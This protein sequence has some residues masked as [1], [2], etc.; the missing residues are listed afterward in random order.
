MASINGEELTQKVKLMYKDVAENPTGKY[1]FEMGRELAKKLG[2]LSEDLEQIPAEALGSFA[3][4]GYYFD[5]AQLKEGDNVL[6]LGS[7]SGTDSFFAAKKIGQGKVMGIDM[8]FEQLNKANKLKE[9]Y[10]FGNVSFKEGFIESLPMENESF[11]VVISNGVINLSPDK[12][13]AFKE[14]SRV[15][16]TGGKMAIADIV[17]EK[18]LTDKIT[19][20]VNVWA[21]CIGGAMQIDKFKQAI[22][23]SGMKIVSIKENPKYQ[24][25]SK[26]AQGAT[27]DFGVKSICILAEKTG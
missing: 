26:S 16:K 22:S 1:H 2:Y 11:D 7:G 6:D 12:E 27:R 23:N 4:V 25:L 19:C 9:I 5:L 14:I 24:F 21:S 15:L 3:G 8:T 10:N 20:D 17:T 18:Q 13:Q